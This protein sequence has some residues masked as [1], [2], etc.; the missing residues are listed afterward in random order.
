MTADTTGHDGVALVQQAQLAAVLIH[1]I[2]NVVFCIVVNVNT[3]VFSGAEQ[4]QN[5]FQILLLA[6]LFKQRP[7]LLGVVILGVFGK[8]TVD[9]P[10]VVIGGKV[11][12]RLPFLGGVQTDG[13]GLEVITDAHGGQALFTQGDKQ[14]LCH[15]VALLFKIFVRRALCAMHDL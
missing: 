5:L 1:H 10:A 8:D 3:E 7:G 6:V 12:I 13:A 9:A 11:E 4:I 15:N 2:P 14:T